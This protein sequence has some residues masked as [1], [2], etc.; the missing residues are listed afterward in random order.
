MTRWYACPDCHEVVPWLGRVRF[1]VG[2]TDPKPQWMCAGCL[3]LLNA[4]EASY[5]AGLASS[6]SECIWAV[7]IVAEKGQRLAVG[8]A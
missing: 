6:A 4:A 5:S 7:E 2:L 8:A 3:E 1:A